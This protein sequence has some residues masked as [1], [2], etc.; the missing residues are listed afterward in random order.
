MKTLRYIIFFMLLAPLGVPAFFVGLIL[1][2][3]YDMAYT[4]ID[5]AKK[6]YE[7]FADWISDDL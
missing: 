2:W 3:I 4:G 1:F 5:L 7:S 6:T